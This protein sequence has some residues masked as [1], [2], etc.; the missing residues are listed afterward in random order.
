MRA[1]CDTL[2]ASLSPDDEAKVMA[3]SEGSSQPEEALRAYC[4]RTMTDTPGAFEAVIATI[5]TKLLPSVQF[6]MGLLLTALSTSFGTFALTGSW[7][8]FADLPF[9]TRE[10]ALAGFA[11]SL[12]GPKRKAFLFLKGVTCAKCLGVSP[13]ETNRNPSWDAVGYDGPVDSAAFSDEFAFR[14]ANDDLV[15]AD[16]AVLRYDA[17]V[18]GTG[19]GGSI[20]AA[21]LAAAGANVLVLEKGTYYKRSDLRGSEAE[22]FNNLYEA[23]ATTAT[24]DSGISVLAGSTFGGGTAVNWACSL[25]T[26]SFVRQEWSSKYGL[27]RFTSNEYDRDLDEVFARIGVKEGE[28]VA[29]NEPNAMLLNG[30][31]KCG[32]NVRTAGQNVAS[33]APNEA[34]AEISIGDRFG[35]KQSTPETYL[36]DAARHGAAFMDRCF[37]SKVTQRGGKATGV[38]GTVVGAGG[39]ERAFTVEASI[40]VVSCGSINSPALLLRSKLPGLNKSGQLGK[41]LRLHPVIGAFGRRPEGAEQNVDMWKGAPMST[42][43]DAVAAG[44]DGDFYGAKLEVP[45]VLP[46]MMS[47]QLPWRSA[48]EYKKWVLQLRRF[49]LLIVLCRD[50]GSG[51]VTIDGNG[52]A[53]MHYPLDPHDRRSMEDGLEA[54]MR[55]LAADGCDLIG[56][57][58]ARFGD[59]QITEL[60][61]APRGGESEEEFCRLEAARC[62]AVDAAV[63][64]MRKVG[65]TSDFRCALFSAH[66]MGTCRM[67]SSASNSVVKPNGETWSVE[68]L[69][70]A[71][72]SVFPTPS[73]ANPM[74]TTMAINTGTGRLLAAKFAKSRGSKL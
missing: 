20:V 9:K 68:N 58:Q 36:Q 46:G 5:E 48:A 16:G 57:G 3:E 63:S 50:R 28:E 13:A 55:C 37:V 71:D 45:S 12:L 39:V 60:P 34:V 27:P 64:E 17:V 49:C 47:A 66:Q 33:C 59:G 30:A 25:R 4:K 22:G 14:M 72:A 67:G 74:I 44:C 42:V 40:V 23:G 21:K 19:C 15:G 52:D 11:T 51:T 53:R 32:Y 6:E 73:G 41:N 62:A 26:P 29:H 54:S 69:Y 8:V 2:I 43:S 7:G 10:A 35:L 65:V 70:V 56:T 18:V 24:E 31:R 1:V 38:V 61:P